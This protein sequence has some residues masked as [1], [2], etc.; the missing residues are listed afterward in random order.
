[1]GILRCSDE[2]RD[3]ERPRCKCQWPVASGS[4]GSSAA[5]AVPSG[6]GRR[7]RPKRPTAPLERC[8][9]VDVPLGLPLEVPLVPLVVSRARRFCRFADRR[10][11]RATR[12]ATVSVYGI[13]G[14]A[15]CA[16]LARATE[17]LGNLGYCSGASTRLGRHTEMADTNI[18]KKHVMESNPLYP[19]QGTAVDNHI[20]MPPMLRHT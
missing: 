12:L 17:H 11:Q 4:S 20:H 15:W 13:S 3:Q 6:R 8:W 1:M 18:C 2:A 7:Q 14:R 19:V 10:R 5:A 9:R 16:T